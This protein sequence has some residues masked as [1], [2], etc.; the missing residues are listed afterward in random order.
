MILTLAAAAVA[1]VPVHAQVSDAERIDS[2]TAEP[3]PPPI[4]VAPAP[5]PE[6]R[7]R[8]GFIFGGH[9][10][11]TVP[12]GTIPVSPY[13][14]CGWFSTCA[15]A[16]FTGDISGIGFAYALD[17]SLRLG[18]RLLLGLTLEHAS[19]GTGRHPELL[20]T[21][22]TGAGTPTSV[23]SDT[24]LLALVFSVVINPDRTSLY[25]DGGVGNRWYGFSATNPDGLAHSY[26]G[27][28]G[29]FGLGLWIP[30]SDSVRLLPKV[31]LSAGTFESPD[32]TGQEC[33]SSEHGF[34]LFNLAGLYNLDL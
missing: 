8:V 15:G 23:S 7:S 27:A 31:T 6:R 30:V 9:L 33:W 16:R 20:A 32:C 11:V 10:G 17:A 5:K 2:G 34:L 14:G 26:S 29:F 24:T 19:F 18:R 1:V 22:A 13:S 3:T 25:I 12:G 21:G 4:Y 28:E